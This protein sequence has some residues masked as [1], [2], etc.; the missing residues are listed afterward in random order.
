MFSPEENY[1]KNFQGGFTFV[2]PL[3]GNVWD[4]WRLDERK[5]KPKPNQE[6]MKSYMRERAESTENLIEYII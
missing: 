5:T 3:V 4:R 1:S 6:G 2:V